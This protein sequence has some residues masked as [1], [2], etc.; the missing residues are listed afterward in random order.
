MNVQHVTSAYV[1]AYESPPAKNAA[2]PAPRVSGSGK[3]AVELS[4]SSVSLQKIRD[5]IDALPEVR[6][7]LVED[8]KEKIRNNDYP[9]DNYLQGALDKMI[10]NGILQTA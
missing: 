1:Q 6:I 7:Q 5:K 3:E 10:D 2:K 8:I 4:A 9:L